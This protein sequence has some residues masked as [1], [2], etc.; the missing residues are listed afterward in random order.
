MTYK[1]EYNNSVDNLQVEHQI[2]TD[3]HQRVTYGYSI[4]NDLHACQ[5]ELTTKDIIA[6]HGIFNWKKI[7]GIQADDTWHKQNGNEEWIFSVLTGANPELVCQMLCIP[8][9]HRKKIQTK[10]KYELENSANFLRINV[11]SRAVAALSKV[12]ERKTQYLA[13]YSGENQTALYRR[14]AAESF[15]FAAGILATNIKT[16]ISID[17]QLPLSPVLREVL[18]LR[19]GHKISKGLLKR[20]N[21]APKIPESCSLEQVLL[22][23]TLIPLDWIPNTDEQWNAYCHVAKIFLSTLNAPTKA[24]STMI[25]GCSGDWIKLLRKICIEGGHNPDGGINAADLV[26]LDAQDMLIEFADT[27]VIPEAAKSKTLTDA[28]VTPE[29]R[30]TAIQSAFEILNAGRTALGIAENTRRW[31]NQ[32]NVISEAIRQANGEDDTELD[33]LAQGAW[34][35]LTEN[36]QSPSGLHIIP[37]NSPDQLEWEGISGLDPSG[38]KGLDH[39]ISSYKH[40]ALTGDCHI[41]SIRE[42]HKNNSFSRLCTVEF[43]R[44][45]HHQNYLKVRQAKGYRNSTPEP[46]ALDA[47]DWYIKSVALNKI[48]IN[49]NNIIKFQEKIGKNNQSLGN[50]EI[51]CGYDWRIP[52]MVE[53]V[54]KLWV[55]FVADQWKKRKVSPTD[56]QNEISIVSDKILPDIEIP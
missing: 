34:P 7:S 55:P 9:M 28:F 16:K 43:E 11:D 12:C 23:S 37:L 31:S 33:K 29:I 56:T 8:I 5:I 35:A 25:N 48:P 10:L 21:S 19:T 36:V 44:P 13:F 40:K 54:A 17:R 49:W 26:M 47:L 6:R 3:N 38:N 50:L 14:Q 52:G 51:R 53:K 18:E 24:I 1:T 2:N 22:F 27:Y 32:R 39:C 41:V 46:K 20:L 30:M 42:M 15:P 45:K 4:G